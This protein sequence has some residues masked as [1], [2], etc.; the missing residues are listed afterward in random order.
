MSKPDKIFNDKKSTIEDFDF[1]EKTAE[2]FDDMLDRSVPFYAEI[3]RMISEMA[4]DF[5]VPGT[6]I[7]DLGCSTCNTF[8]QIDPLLPKDV[9]FVGVD[10]S[11]AMLDRA[12]E[13]LARS[14]VTRSCELVMGNLNEGV[15]LVY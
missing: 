1:G 13:K 3:Q 7:Y 11:E 15:E 4:A 2:V 10:S 12:R 6:N 14:G 9:A 5:A 8:V